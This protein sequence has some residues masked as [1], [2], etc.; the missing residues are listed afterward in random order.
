MQV[1]KL[2]ISVFKEQEKKNNIKSHERSETPVRSEA[3]GKSA[4]IK[5][6]IIVDLNQRLREVQSELDDA[7]LQKKKLVC[8]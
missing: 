7:V 4:A 8:F 1:A 5:N 3:R 6:H 2:E